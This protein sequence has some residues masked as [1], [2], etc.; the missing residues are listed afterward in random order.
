MGKPNKKREKGE[1]IPRME[2][3]VRVNGVG[4]Q[5]DSEGAR[6]QSGGGGV[7]RGQRGRRRG[8]EEKRI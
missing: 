4:R 7:A 8:D 6:G 3:G 1:K 5:L 2:E